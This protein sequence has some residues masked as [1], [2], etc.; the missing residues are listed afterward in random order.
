MHHIAKPAYYGIN[1]PVR[2]E[3]VYEDHGSQNAEVFWKSDKE[4][5]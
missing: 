1:R 4:T 5:A 2:E 3:Y